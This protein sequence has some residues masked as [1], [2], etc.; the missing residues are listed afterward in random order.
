MKTVILMVWVAC[1]GPWCE[2]QASSS[3]V[4]PWPAKQLAPKFSKKTANGLWQVFEAAND[5]CHLEV[6]FQPNVG[7]SSRRALELDDC[8]AVVETRYQLLHA[9]TV[10]ADWAEERGGQAFVFHR[11]AD[12]HLNWLEVAYES[13]DE[14]SLTAQMAQQVI[15]LKAGRHR[16]RVDVL[17]DG[18][19]KL[20]KP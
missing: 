3:A 9:D 7:A 16:Y 13:G 4:A 10:L 20:R 14:E 12:Q 18:Q 1:F 11:T 19:L 2:A 15:R 17:P 5:G 8:S 6:H